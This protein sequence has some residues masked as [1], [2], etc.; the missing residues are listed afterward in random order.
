MFLVGNPGLEESYG[1]TTIRTIQVGHMR[2]VRMERTSKL[3]LASFMVIGLIVA[4]LQVKAPSV[5]A[6]IMQGAT[7]I[8]LLGAV[9][10]VIA[11]VILNLDRR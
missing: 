7:V 4:V 2:Y 9:V 11:F 3:I 8:A 10:T 1:V 5:L 6:V